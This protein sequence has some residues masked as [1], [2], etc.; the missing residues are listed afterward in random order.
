MQ[1]TKELI[2]STKKF[3]EKVFYEFTQIGSLN[4]KE[5][6]SLMDFE[7]A[8]E[9]LNPQLIKEGKYT[10]SRSYY[11]I[12]LNAKNK[13]ILKNYL[14]IFNHNRIIELFWGG[15][16]SGHKAF[17][18]V[19]SQFYSVR[20][21]IN[22]KPSIIICIDEGDLY[23]H[24]MWQQEFLNR[25]LHYL[26]SIVKVDIQIILTSHSPFLVSDL[27][28]RNIIY[29][30]RNEE[31]MCMVKPYEESNAET[32]GANLLDLYANSFFLN[33]GT[34][35]KFAFSKIKEVV[36]LLKEPVIEKKNLNK[37]THIISI[38]GDDVIKLKLSKMLEDAKISN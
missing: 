15:I 29:L 14:T 33:S 28:R 7:R 11:L 23:L 26:R 35:S 12:D 22:N 6:M 30:D 16:S 34:I 27:P 10:Q 38:V 5:A 13:K 31:Q 17:L 19:F 25:L 32:F 1:N 36:E 4:K 37:I 21:K 8:I 20:K 2:E 9:Y 24:P 3:I 18:N